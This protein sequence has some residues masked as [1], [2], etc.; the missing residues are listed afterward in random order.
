MKKRNLDNIPLSIRNY[1]EKTIYNNNLIIN[2][3]FLS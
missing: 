3:T 2:F 1:I